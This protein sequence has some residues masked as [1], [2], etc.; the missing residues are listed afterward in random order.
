MFFQVD[1]PNAAVSLQVL[2]PA[3]LDLEVQQPSPDG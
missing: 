3:W 1:S 2:G